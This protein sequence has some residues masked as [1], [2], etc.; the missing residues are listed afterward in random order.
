GLG[1]AVAAAVA[2]PLVAA[3]VLVRRSVRQDAL[4]ALARQAALIAAQQARPASDQGLNSLGVFFETQQ[5]R[6]A[7]ISLSQASLLLPSA[8][9]AELRAGQP[10]TGSVDVGGRSYLY[11]ARP[12][13][14]R[15]IVL[16]P[17]A[18]LQASHRPPFTLP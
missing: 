14:G 4:T 12:S 3:A 18:Q 9:A 5:E 15:A 2:V 7:I 6:L 11:A 16:L 1:G 17:S 13:R 8:G 10:A